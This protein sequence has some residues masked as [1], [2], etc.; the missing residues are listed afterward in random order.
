MKNILLSLVLGLAGLLA[1]CNSS[2]PTLN[3]ITV[4]TPT[5]SVAAGLTATFT[6]TGNYSNNTTQN[7]TSSVTWTSSN[8]AVATI[9]GGTATTL[10][11]G[12]T[13]ITA[14]MSGVSGMAT[15]TVTAPVLDSIAVTPANDT[16]PVG[17]LT[18]FT[19]TGT[20]SDNSTQNL[21]ST[22]TWSSSNTTDVTISATGLATALSTTTAPITITATSGTISGTTGLTVANATLTSI[23]LSGAPT[24]TIA[25]GTSYQ[26]TAWGFYDDGS[27]RNITMQ[28]TWSSSNSSVATIGA[29]TGRA[30]GVAGGLPA[31]TITATLGS[32]TG[33]AAL[34]VTTATIQ[35]IT[36]GPSTTTIAPQTVESFAAIGTFSDMSTQNITPDVVWASSSTGVASISNTAGSVGVATAGA[37]PGGTTS[38]SATFTFGGATATGSAPLTVSA[39][40]LTS[41]TLTPATASMAES[42]A[43]YTS[44][45][46][47]Q[48]VGNFSDGS[49]QH[50]ET[51]AT[52]SSSASSVA[53]VSSIGI[54]T[55]GLS[56]GPVAIL[57]QLNGVSA[58]ASLT[59][60]AFTAITIKPASGTVAP[61]T[62]IALMATG[63]LTDGTTQNLTNSVL[64][65]SSSPSLATMSNASGSFG[66]AEGIAPGA[67]TITAAFSGM[68]GVASLTVSDATLTSI[69]IKPPNPSIALGAHQ[70]FSATGTFSDGSTEPL[71]GQV[72]WTSSDIGVA[73]INAT[74]AISTTGTGTSMIGASLNQVSGTTVLTVN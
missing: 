35:A 11:Q 24:V 65:T 30:E 68:V 37:A 33:T 44:N 40:T 8:T 42:S 59:V 26:F 64:W 62:A 34:N 31:T 7:L 29:A 50:I 5:P 38:I 52:W 14:S 21:T 27:K 56:T 39:A 74:G 22:A 49:T 10:T 13:T 6:A 67:V 45:L 23:V 69:T 53:T 25:F 73:L 60:E 9:A 71:T 1:G 19:A 18:Q 55:A 15:L 72:S 4:T 51:V 12:S 17:T 3:S 43:N 16:V 61:G 20:Y 47:L 54:V 41:I 46:T 66:Q 58:T 63:T 32:V 48:A 28:A 57:C 2:A 36:V 70:Q